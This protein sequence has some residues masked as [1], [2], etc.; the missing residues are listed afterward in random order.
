MPRTTKLPIDAVIALYA[1]YILR[2]LRVL[3]Q[4]HAKSIDYIYGTF[5]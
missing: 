3:E 5:I 1:D 2:F 4:R